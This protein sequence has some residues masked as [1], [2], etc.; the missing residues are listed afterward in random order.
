MA[1]TRRGHRGAE[2]ETRLRYEEFV[3]GKRARKEWKARREGILDLCC[4]GIGAAAFCL[5]R[6]PRFGS[7]LKRPHIS[8][9]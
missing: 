9:D 7:R 4:S 2:D 3:R 5:V 6:Q 8:E 1:G